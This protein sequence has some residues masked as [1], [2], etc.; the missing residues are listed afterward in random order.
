VGIEDKQAREQ[1][2]REYKDCFDGIGCFEGEFHITTDPDVL[3]VVHAPRRIPLALQDALK[4][5]LGVLEKQHIIAKVQKPTDWVNSIVCVTKP[6]GSLRLCLDPKDLNAAIKRPHHVMPT[7][8]DVLPKLKGGKFFSI[9]DARSGYWNIKL[10]TESSYLTTFATP[11]GRYRFLRLPFGLVCAQDVFQKKVDETFGDLPGVTGIADDIVVWGTDGPD[12]D[13]NLKRVLDRARETGIRLNA[14]KLKVKCEKIA[15]F[16]NVIGANGLEPHSA[17]LAAINNMNPPQDVKELETFLGLATYLGRFTPQLAELAA[18]L[19]DLCKKDVLFSWQQAQQDAFDKLKKELL[20]S[21]VLKFFDTAKP[22]TIQVDAS[23]R[24][25]GAALLQE[26]GPIEYA[27]KTLSDTES[28]YSNIE[29][30]MLGVLFGLERF[31][32]YAYGRPV[33]VETDHKPLEAIFKKH[34]DKAPPRISRMMLRIQKYDVTIKYVPG[35]EILLADA[36]SRVNPCSGDEIKD[37]QISVHEI[38]SGLNATPMR[39]KSIQEAT[40][41]DTTL[42]M[43]A[44]TIQ[45]GWPDQHSQCNPQLMP[46]WNYR[47]ELYVA[48]GMVLKGCRII[49][50][51]VLQSEA[52]RQLHCAH[53]GAEKSKLRARSAI[54]WA[55]I[56]KDIDEMIRKC[57]ICQKYQAGNAKEPLIPH[58]VPKRPW[59]KLGIDLFYLRNENYLLLADYGSKFPIVKKLKTTSSREVINRLKEIFSEH[60]IPETLISDNGPQ[61][62]AAEFKEFAQEYGFD[63]TTSSPLYPQSN[64]FIERCVQTVKNIMKKCHDSRSDINMALL[65]LRTTPV[66]HNIPA[67]CMVLNN[68]LY[69]TN[70]PTASQTTHINWNPDSLESRQE[71]QKSY[72][73][74]GA[75]DLSL[76]VPDQPVGVL[77][78]VNKTW[79]PGTI[80]RAAETPRSYHVESNGATYRRNRRHIRVAPQRSENTECQDVQDNMSDSEMVYRPADFPLHNSVSPHSSPS[81]SHQLP[82]PRRSN[83]TSKPPVRLICEP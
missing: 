77:D 39:I 73:D 1:V 29:R 19:R 48:D 66:S 79:S 27:S 75:K 63:H 78:P 25:L 43:L 20:S 31:H 68:R 41:N 12:H 4:Y 58:D 50:P 74:K 83:R 59:H 7:L 49:I 81:A 15:F 9:L 67:P 26:H 14:E 2:L 35:K 69:K 18:P 56:N 57:T 53:Q 80:L 54:F 33:S 82:P 24:G 30:E 22:V 71:R 23:M 51:D 21:R 76:L 28:R 40:S 32:Y 38:H 37:L 36:L 5:E 34:L 60:G 64:G 65:C 62:S 42:Q 13:A 16:G 8:D 46:F 70:I 3:P 11:F 6:N 44:Q 17:K 52:L 55:N 47:D 72:H 10:S 45:K 61:F